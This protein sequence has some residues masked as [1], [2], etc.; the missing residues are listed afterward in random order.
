VALT[1]ELS[2]DDARHLERCLELAARARRTAA[3]NPLVG[4]VVVRDGRVLGE[5]FHLRPG[6]PHAEVEALQAAGDAHGATVY[7][8]LEP[9]CH[10]G[11][12]PPCT[13][14]LL[15]AG[16]ARVVI[17]ALDPDP[18]VDGGGV[19]RL[20]DAGVAVDM[21]GG[22]LERRARR[23]NA[24]FLTLA[25]LGRPHVTLKAA[26]SLDGRTATAAGESQWI[27][28]PHSRA[29]VHELR[30]A[31]GAV[32]VGVGTAVADDPL[33]TVRDVSPPPER[34]PLRVV[35]DRG[36]RLPTSSR[37]VVSAAE[38]PLLVV[39]A[40]GAPAERVE[41]LRRAGA[42]VVAAATAADALAEL[43]R[44][45]ITSLLV[46][47]GAGLAAGLLREGLVDRVALFV[48]PLLLGDG[49]GLI[50]GW[51]AE[52]LAA[53][54]RA[55]RLEAVPCGPDILVEADLRDV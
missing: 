54:P 24:A 15:A 6:A 36:A 13:D 10:H 18:R 11:R 48:A 23:L 8:S 35:F 37:L 1:G 9:C 33:L 5:G 49:P 51:A 3:P 32:A 38:A 17:G 2:A 31:A 22:E 45:R 44:R 14:A 41:A 7:V 52:T 43:G 20:R 26:V 4:A 25:R 12:T 28:S 42:D 55:V 47:G 39:A 50:D 34:Q 40:Q 27:S 19:R 29:A 46:E 16:V 53:A 30:A 21:A